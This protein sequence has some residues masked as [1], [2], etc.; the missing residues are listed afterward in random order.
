VFWSSIKTRP[1]STASVSP[2]CHRTCASASLQAIVGPRSPHNVTPTKYQEV[3]ILVDSGSQQT[4]LCSTAVAERLGASG[5]LNSFALQAGGQ[6]LPINGRSCRTYFKSAALSPFDVIL[7][8]SWLKEHRGVLDYADNRLWQKDPAGNLR[9]LTFD[10][11]GI[12]MPPSEVNRIG[13][14][15]CRM[16]RRHASAAFSMQSYLQAVL[17]F[18]KELPEDTELDL[19]NIPGITPSA[20]A[21]FSFVEEEVR[22]QL[23]Y[24]PESQLHEIVS[25]RLRSFEGDVFETRTQLRPPPI[26]PGFEVP[27]VEKEGSEP[28]ARRPY[29]VAPHHQPELDRQVKALFDAGII[30]RSSSNYSAPVLFTPKKDGKLR[31]VVDYRMLNTQTVR[32][33]FPTPTAGDLIAKTRG[34]KL[35]SKI[36]LLSGFHQLRMSKDAVRKTAFATPSDCTDTTVH[37]S[38]TL[39]RST[40]RRVTTRRTTPFPPRRR[41][42][43]QTS[44]GTR[45]EELCSLRLFYSKDPKPVIDMKPTFGDL[46][47]SASRHNLRDSISRD[48]RLSRIISLQTL[49]THEHWVFVTLSRPCHVTPASVRRTTALDD[50]VPDGSAHMTAAAPVG[51]SPCSQRGRFVLAGLTLV[52]Q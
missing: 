23:A 13:S 28:Q 7:G 20:R 4:P 14:R 44:N 49:T 3:S 40:T 8:E 16:R 45:T 29:P 6:P 47:S 38:T 2:L 36:D 34:V 41:H 33:R 15:A 5:K 1:L 48:F 9:P 19:V 51:V 26:R 50:G 22:A 52:S 21:S 12:D 37:A 18:T 30:R 46:G 11:P 43:R 24:L 35:F 32:D 39:R 10:K 42:T 31:M 27:I 25:R 17:D